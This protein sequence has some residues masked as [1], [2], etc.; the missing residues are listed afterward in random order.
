MI[1]HHTLK[2]WPVQFVF[3][4]E[5]LRKLDDELFVTKIYLNDQIFN[6]V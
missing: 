2:Y 6:V 4:I 5:K 3:S 1:K